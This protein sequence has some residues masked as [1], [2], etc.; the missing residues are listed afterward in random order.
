MSSSSAISDRLDPQ[1]APLRR[2]L[3]H[4]VRHRA[5]LGIVIVLSIIGAGFTLAQPVLVNQILSTVSQ[6]E[7][8]RWLVVGLTL[9]VIGEA[10]IGAGQQYL[11][12]RTGEAV[13]LDSRRGLIS[14]LLRLR[15]SQYDVQSSGDLV[16]RVGADTTM[17]RA[18]LTGGLVDAVGSSLVFIGALIA[19][20][21]LDSVL[22]GIT[23]TV[24]TLAVL[25]VV[26]ASAHIQR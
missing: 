3:G 18:A 20:L 7:A 8:I 25:C 4:L 12:E 21:L 10:V 22:L 2:L 9:L 11:L 19:M 1:P 23:V 6:G 24:V 13:V 17:V 14:R 26:V 15:I 16:T 5:A